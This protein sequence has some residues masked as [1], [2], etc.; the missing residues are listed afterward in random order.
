MRKRRSFQQ[1]VLSA[2]YTEINSK[3]II[4]INVR[5]KSIKHLKENI[6]ENLHDF[7]LGKELLNVIAKAQAIREKKPDKSD[8]I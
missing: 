3:C 8:F 7:W 5:A 6:G 1:T 4:D 2:P